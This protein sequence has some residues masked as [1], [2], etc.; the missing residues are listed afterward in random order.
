MLYG[1]W[2]AH[3]P[4]IGF[5]L[6]R[7]YASVA[8]MGPVWSGVSFGAIVVGRGAAAYFLHTELQSVGRAVTAGKAAAGATAAK[9]QTAGST[10][11]QALADSATTWHLGSFILLATLSFWFIRLLVRIFLS[12]LHL[13]NDA[14]E[15]VTM[16]KTYLALIRNDDLPKGDNISTVLAALFRPTGDG[17]VKDERVPPTTLEWFTKLR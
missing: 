11:V 5:W 4:T 10:T 1:P 12:N 8:L 9:A 3:Q 7:P 13:E 15:R 16:A 17:I 6:T 14:A 2:G